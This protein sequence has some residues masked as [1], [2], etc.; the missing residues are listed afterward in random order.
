MKTDGVYGTCV[1]LYTFAQLARVD[2]Y[3]YRCR[4]SSWVVYRFAGD[5]SNVN[6]LPLFIVHNWSGNHFDAVRDMCTAQ[7][8][9]SELPHVSGAALKSTDRDH[10][11]FPSTSNK[12][13][14]KITSIAAEQQTAVENFINQFNDIGHNKSLVI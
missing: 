12:S 14:F 1:E 5:R 8:V 4:Y 3:V 11:L 10:N 6:I 13:D 2:I 9:D 7:T